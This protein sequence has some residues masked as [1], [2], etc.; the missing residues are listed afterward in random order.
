MIN[1]EYSIKEKKDHEHTLLV[2]SVQSSVHDR[3]QDY[4]VGHIFS[5]E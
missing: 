2:E 4:E 1:P 3:V 5:L